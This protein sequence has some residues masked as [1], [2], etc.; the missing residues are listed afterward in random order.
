MKA[1]IPKDIQDPYAVTV[2]SCAIDDH[3]G[4][5]AITQ[6]MQYTVVNVNC[7]INPG[8]LVD[9]C[10]EL[11]SGHRAVVA[12]V[13][14]VRMELSLM[15]SVMEEKHEEMKSV[16]QKK[17]E[18]STQSMFQ[19]QQQLS[20]IQ[21]EMAKLVAQLTGQNNGVTSPLIRCSKSGCN[22]VVVKRFRSGK[23]PRQCSL[24]LGYAHGSKK[25][26]LSVMDTQKSSMLGMTI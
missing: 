25:R 6:P 16:M 7:M 14:S 21:H 18:T 13:H 1:A 17:E 2:K 22:R 20:N 19:L 11:R 3:C 24:H 12:E 5:I 23:A 4:S 15:K 26:S 9:V 8:I 10:R